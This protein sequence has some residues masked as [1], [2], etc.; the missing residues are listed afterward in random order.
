[1]SEFKYLESVVDESGTYVA[2]CHR[3]VVSRRKAAGTVRSLVNA[4]SLQLQYPRVL[5]KS[6]CACSV[7]WQ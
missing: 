5:H 6:V 2:E 1:M 4:R 7:V 3:E